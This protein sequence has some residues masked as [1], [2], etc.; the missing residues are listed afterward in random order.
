MAPHLDF[1]SYLQGKE[2]SRTPSNSFMQ[3]L[4]VRKQAVSPN[5]LEQKEEHNDFHKLPQVCPKHR[6]EIF[7]IKLF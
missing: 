6:S 1:T 3:F 5:D 4:P 7:K 2:F